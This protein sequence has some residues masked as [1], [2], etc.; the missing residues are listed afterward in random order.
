MAVSKRKG[1]WGWMFFDWANQPFHTLI[2][3][4]IFAPYFADF[5]AASP[6][7]GQAIWGFALAV[8][9]LMIAVAAPFLGAVADASGPRRPW[10]IGFSVLYVTG[11][12]G[13]W[14]AVPGADNLTLILIFF[15]IGLIGAEFALVFVN[16][17]LPLL[18]TRDELGRI[19]G[20]AW[21][22]G[23]WGGL[24]SLIIVLTLMVPA[25][26]STNTLIGIAPIFGLD[27]ELGE[28]ARAT[29]PMSA[30]WYVVFMIPFFLWS[31]DAPRNS[32]VG[33]AVAKGLRELYQTI[34]TLPRQRSLF[35]YL[36]SS[37]FY[38]DALNGLYAFGG[39]YAAG[40]LG[41][42]TFQL[43][44]FGI[45]AAFAGAVGAWLGGRADERFGPKPV[46][47]GAIWALIAVSALTVSTGPNEVLFV[48]VGAADAPS[49]LPSLV[50]YICGAVIGAAGGSLQSASRTMLVR[51]ADPAKMTEAFGIYA[52]AGRATS[53]L[54]P[55][56]IATVTLA[57]E[58]QRIGVTPV[59]ALFLIG[60]IFL[61]WVRADGRA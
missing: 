61:I 10:I 25:P 41:W 53:F 56:L 27:P 28:G 6:E 13:L 36:G 9:G 3:T 1:I 59:I 4:F 37:M 43:G 51:Q 19:S 31:P 46:I 54:A 17:L 16:S 23:Y 50:F 5:V 42:G 48:A 52:L 2:I 15:V 58:S 40:V 11:M 21:A 45:I 32:A 44:I 60:L 55:F 24:T 33:G 49:G 18:G 8:G 38:R 47:I 20:S 22:M 26:G 30:I 34:V 35:A 7:E 39:I 57:S 29:G 14:M 12:G